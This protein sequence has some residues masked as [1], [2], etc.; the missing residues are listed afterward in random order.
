MAD[1]GSLL[2]IPSYAYGWGESY[3]HCRVAA[4]KCLCSPLLYKERMCI[5]STSYFAEVHCGNDSDI[6]SSS[7]RGAAAEETQDTCAGQ[8]HQWCD[9]DGHASIHTGSH[10]Q[11]GYCLGSEAIIDWLGSVLTCVNPSQL[12]RMTRNS[13]C[14][15]SG[16]TLTTGYTRTLM[17]RTREIRCLLP[18]TP[19]QS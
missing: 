9:A 3:F 13:H 2:I 8:R 7:G 1:H 19:I 11:Y 15:G 17:L 16:S 18:S 14:Q 6:N 4:S 12:A 10:A 5:L